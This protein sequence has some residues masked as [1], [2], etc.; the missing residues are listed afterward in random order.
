VTQ[1][2]SNQPYKAFIYVMLDGGMDSFNLLVPHTCAKRNSN[3]KTLLEQYFIERTSL[4]LTEEERSR[5]IDSIGQPCSQ[6][7][8]HQN[9]EIVE[10]L[11]KNRDL[12][13]FANA[14]ALNQ[15]VKKENYIQLTKTLLF[16]HNTMIEEAQKVDPYN[17]APG[18]GILGRM[19]DRLRG[20]GFN[21]Q[22]ITIQD[23]SIATVGFPG[24][25]VD[26]LLVSP[27]QTTKFN[28]TNEDEN[29]MVKQYVGQLNDA[30]VQQSSLYGE[31]WSKFLQ[32][33][34]FDNESILK[35]LSIAQ[36]NTVFPE[37]EFSLQL[38]VVT[39]LITSYKQRG[40]DQ[41]VFFV[42]LSGWDQH[43]AMK[44]SLA[45]NFALLND[46]LTAFHDEMKAKGLWKHVSL[47]VTSEFAQA[48]TANSSDGSD[49]GWGGN[50]FL[51]GGAVNGGRILESYQ[52][53]IT[54]IGDLAVGRGNILPTLSWESILNP[55][56]QWMGAE[57]ESD[58]DYAMP[59][60]KK[61]GAKLFNAN[62][63]F[64]SESRIF[65]E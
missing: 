22:P 13:F 24:A 62:E 8:I 47:L 54:P 1:K 41:D 35:T 36:L 6:F 63:V 26:P 10:R 53:D 51:M 25:A 46:A 58:L 29:F 48:L 14:G 11:Y 16:G 9:L 42:K 40:T 45:E 3:G 7:V 55:V 12:V 23:A 4:A 52:D 28:P 60:R 17:S 38:R 31:T 56:V 39:T 32:K 33:A 21:V 37:T 50:Y 43:S 64:D 18:T 59:N 19:C 15:P 65:W 34:V 57:S 5:V 61:T 44:S 27:F 30:A 20:K 2:P 49:H